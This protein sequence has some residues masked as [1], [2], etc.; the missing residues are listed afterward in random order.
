MRN[1]RGRGKRA[2]CALALALTLGFGAAANA[3]SPDALARQA[4]TLQGRVQTLRSAYLQPLETR[5]R[6]DV[7]SRVAEGR[8]RY[9]YGEYAN[10][11]VLFVSV[12]E[13]PAMQ[14]QPGYNDALYMLADSLF[15][16]RDFR[17]SRRYFEDVI[18]RRDPV[19]TG[20]A[21]RRLLEIALALNDYTGL[22]ELYAQLERTAGAAAGPELAY[23][24]GKALY[25][26]GRYSDAQRALQAVP[27]SHALAGRAAYFQGVVLARSGNVV[28][29]QS[30]FQQLLSDLDGASLDPEGAALPDLTALALG[31]V[32]YEQGNLDEAVQA[33][34]LVPG[35]SEYYDDALF[36]MAW[37][38]VRQGEI[39]RAIEQLEILE[40]VAQDK[41]LV[42]EAQLLRAD[43]LL[44]V[45]EFDRAQTQFER[46][47][48]SYGPVE[49]ELREMTRHAR[50]SDEYFDA[51]VSAETG[52]LRLPTLARPWFQRTDTVD[53]A[54][55]MVQDFEQMRQDL[56]LCRTVIGELDGVLNNAGGVEIFPV[57]RE[58]WGTALETDASVMA[59]RRDAVD[60]EFARVSS[61]LDAGARARHEQLKAARL[62]LEAQYNTLPRTFVELQVRTQQNATG[63][64]ATGLDLY[65]GTLQVEAAQRDIEALRGFVSDQLRQGERTPADAERL[66]AQ[67]SMLEQEFVAHQR[68]AS[69]LRQAVVSRMAESGVNDRDVRQGREIRNRYLAALREEHGHLQS[70]GG[71][72]TLARA[73]TSLDGSADDIERFFSELLGYI[74]T[75]TAGIRA[76]LEEERIAVAGWEAALQGLN[77]DGRRVVGETALQAMLDIQERF[78]RLTL[79]AS[80]GVLDGAW[81]EK[82]DLT[83]QREQLQREQVRAFRSLESDFA[84]IRSE[85]E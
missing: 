20:D 28:A 37:S 24:R 58:G 71:D 65:R 22:E 17:L 34:Q 3:Q 45:N 55:R 85:D 60:Q 13:D 69:E 21:S 23:V 80:L 82:E 64:E 74:A 76:T 49:D 30:Q 11:A 16:T 25:F 68:A 15:E 31:R 39:R 57:W 44:R 50:S 36:E 79:R 56:V 14:Q 33:Y 12:V 73:A 6:F 63:V 32:H 83:R 62:A 40:I 59:A 42:P 7:A 75:Q 47:R 29:A 67:L 72:A 78:G 1:D 51:L 53:R 5:Q 35:T 4:D 61:R 8:L 19:F 43:L 10:A 66:R 46:V 81:R 2:A 54:L 77:D 26:Q 48:D 84:E 52:T 41:R 38:R 70:M 27:A 18:R 9:V